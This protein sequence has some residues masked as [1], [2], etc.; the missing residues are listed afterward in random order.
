MFPF[1]KL[2]CTFVT[3]KQMF[4]L[5][6]AYISKNIQKWDFGPYWQRR[7]L[8]RCTH[9][10]SRSILLTINFVSLQPSQLARNTDLVSLERTEVP[11]Q[12]GQ[13]RSGLL[14]RALQPRVLALRRL[15]SPQ[16]ARHPTHSPLVLL[17]HALQLI[18]RRRRLRRYTSPYHYLHDTCM[19][20][21]IKHFT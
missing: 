8:S 9:R 10:G 11:A 14:L 2:G 4:S 15:Q 18:A 1:V 16:L 5:A 12:R 19:I 17:P 6:L 7:W 3:Y 21:V 13:L 20:N